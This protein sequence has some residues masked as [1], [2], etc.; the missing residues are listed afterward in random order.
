VIQYDIAL[1]YSVFTFSHPPSKNAHFDRFPV[2]GPNV[3][4]VRDSKKVQ[5]N[6]DK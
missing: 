1:T 3:S 4:T 2:I 5:F 6:Y